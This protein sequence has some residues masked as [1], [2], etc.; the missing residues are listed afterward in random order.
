MRNVVFLHKR[1]LYF[2]VTSRKGCV[3]FSTFRIVWMQWYFVTSRKGCVDFSGFPAD[4]IRALENVTSRK[5]CVDFS[6][7]DTN[8]VLLGRNW[9]HPARDAWIL[10]GLYPVVFELE[11]VASRK[12]CVD[13]S[14]LNNCEMVSLRVASRKGCVDF[15]NFTDPAD[16]DAIVASRK[17]CVDFSIVGFSVSCVRC[18]RISQG[19]RG[20]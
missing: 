16:Y 10:A 1:T 11:I 14:E 12:G 19:M 7:N 17:G 13:F 18:C 6:R 2:A 4:T 5:G 3:D 15:S 9:S 20:F 8:S